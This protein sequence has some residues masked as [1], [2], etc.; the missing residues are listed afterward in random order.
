VFRDPQF[1]QRHALGDEQQASAR[2]VELLQA[3]SFLE[4][5][6]VAVCHPY[7]AEARVLL[8]HQTRALCRH[9][10]TCAEECHWHGCRGG[11]CAQLRKQ[12][13]A[14]DI[15]VEPVAAEARRQRHAGAISKQQRR[16]AQQLGVARITG[17]NVHAM[18]VDEIHLQ[19]L[20]GERLVNEEAGGLRH[21]HVPETHAHD[22]GH[23]GR[24][25]PT[26]SNAFP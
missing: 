16:G 1:L 6:E 24:R 11:G 12:V 9:A 15:V 26:R 21:G 2:S 8:H 14:V 18:S 4:R 22:S 5:R 7:H 23:P 17:G 20:A 25:V 13:G 19:S 10:G 3:R